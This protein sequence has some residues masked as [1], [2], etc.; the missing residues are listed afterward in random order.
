MAK[1]DSGGGTE[2]EP[3]VIKKYA[4]RRLYN[5][6]TSRYVTLEQLSEMVK[7]GQDFKVFDAKS[8]DDI[9]RAVLTQIIFEEESKGHNLLPIRFLQQ[10]IRMYGDAL[11]PFVPAYLETAMETFLKNQETLRDQLTSTFGTIPQ[12]RQ[13]DELTKQNLAMMEK[14]VQRFS[15]FNWT[16]GGEPAAETPSEPAPKAPGPKEPA[17]EERIN[18]LLARMEAMQ[19]QLDALAKKEKGE[20]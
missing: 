20:G 4:N 16:S 19:Q 3:V 18:D 17:A 10:L 2:G 15:P 1:G 6:A 5:T 9:T 8:G 11:Q 7:E 12:F 13:F 14:A